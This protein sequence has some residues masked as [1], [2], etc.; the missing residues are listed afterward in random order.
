MGVKI[1]L[2]KSKS[3]PPFRSLVTWLANR[4]AK[5]IATETQA[6]K[7]ITKNSEVLIIAG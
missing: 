3:L 1:L 6:G 5:F 7:L 2:V 4:I